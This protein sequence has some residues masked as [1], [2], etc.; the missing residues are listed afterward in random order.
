MQPLPVPFE[1]I[2]K[3][4]GEGNKGEVDHQHEGQNQHEQKQNG[5][6]GKI[7]IIG[8]I[9]MH[10]IAEKTSGPK[11]DLINLHLLD[12]K[13]GQAGKGQEKKERPAQVGRCEA[14]GAIEKEFERTYKKHNGEKKGA[15]PDKP[16]QAVRCVSAEGPDEVMDLNLSGK[17]AGKG[18]VVG[19][20]RSEA[21]DEKQPGG[22]TDNADNFRPS[23]A[24]RRLFCHRYCGYRHV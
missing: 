1:T 3:P 6:P 7:E 14:K 13:G 18:G 8:Q 9:K 2:E 16:E 24:G 5:G 12:D 19:I 23:F 22:K 17:E 21:K 4:V 10:G 15:E 11:G 20:V